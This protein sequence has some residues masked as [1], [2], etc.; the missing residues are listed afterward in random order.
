MTLIE[1]KKATLNNIDIAMEDLHDSFE[2]ALA[3][4]NYPYANGPDLEGMGLRE[5]AIDFRCHFWDDAS[6]ETYDKHVD[7]INTLKNR[8]LHDF[9]H[10]K[11]GLLQGKIESIAINHEPDDIRHCSLDI[12]FVEQ[13]EEQ[14]S[15]PGASV[16]SAVEEAYQNC[17]V[18]HALALMTE[19]KGVLS[20]VIWAHFLKFCWMRLGI[21]R[22][23]RNIPCPPSSSLIKSILI[24]RGA[25]TC[26]S[27]VESPVNSLQ[28]TM[29]YDST[30]IGRIIRQPGR[31]S[32]KVCRSRDNLWNYPAL[33]LP[34]LN[35]DFSALEDTLS[36]LHEAT[37]NDAA[38]EGGALISRQLKIAIA[39]R[40]A[41]EAAAIYAADA[42]AAKDTSGESDFQ[43]MNIL[44]LESTLAIVRERIADAVEIARE[45]D[46]L[47]TM[48]AELLKQVNSVRL[49]RE[50]MMAVVLDNP[51]P[52]HL[53]CLRYGLTYQDAER[54]TRVNN[55]K[56]PNF[57]EGGI[58]VYAAAR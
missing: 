35:T 57:T 10:P 45:M 19:F 22:R 47:K 52:L 23:C 12:R 49:E 40:M 20:S 37:K 13:M 16:L 30:I 42:E 26:F 43:P 31:N 3:R 54:L 44:E 15:F 24:C 28:A 53:V 33:Y 51:M 34:K 41:L 18:Q 39:E 7:L 38:Q 50:K 25:E 21:V 29:T 1:L 55:I 2:A 6:Q 48:A 8:N 4:Y 14:F 58:N 5:R 17:Q 46:Q 11:Y 9:I 32:Q 36:G 27:S 56:H